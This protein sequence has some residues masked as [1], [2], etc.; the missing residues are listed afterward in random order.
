MS[1]KDNKID[2][3]IKTIEAND[4]KFL[5]L[6]F[7]DINGLPK[8]MAVPLKT[9]ND[10]EDIIEDGLLFDGSSIAGL[11]S[12]NDSDLLA[13]P[14]INTFSTIPWRPEALGTCRFICDIFT[15]E[16][17]PYEGDPRGVLKKSLKKAEK[18]G[19]QFNMGPEPEFF[20]IKEDE[21]GNY[22]PADDAEYFDV[23][24]LDQG[25]DIR[26][27]IVLGLEKLD[28][29][30]EVSHHEVAQGQHEVDFKQHSCLSLSLE[31][32]EAECTATK[33]FSKM[34]RTFSMTLILKN[35]YHRKHYISLEDY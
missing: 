29:D 17:D 1:A 9:A 3:I 7:S 35:R 32:T 19:Y 12:I 30:V 20:I 2:Q 24:P 22:I 16:G 5:K 18:R 27:E 23:E 11:A 31:S 33:A 14:D 10:V 13:K 34:E 28:F 4:I 15:T 25:T 21:N 8:N 26:R 6:Q